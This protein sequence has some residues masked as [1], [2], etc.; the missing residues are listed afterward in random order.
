LR[1]GGGVMASGT[2]IA[3]GCS[4]FCV[5]FITSC[6]LLGSS[7]DTLEP[8]DMGIV[9]D[10]NVQHLEE[11]QLYFGGRYLVG[12]GRKFI[13]FPK[14]Y[15]TIR[16]GL[17]S[18]DPPSDNIVCRSHDGLSIDVEM[19]FQFMFNQDAGDLWRLYMALGTTVNGVFGLIAQEVVQNVFSDYYTLDFFQQRVAMETAIFDELKL[20]LSTFFVTVTSVELMRVDIEDTSPDLVSAV[21]TTQVAIQ[22]VFQA[23]AEQAVAQVNADA[24]VGVATEVAQVQLLNANATA[25]SYLAAVQASADALLYRIDKQATALLTLRDQLGLNTSMEV[26]GYQWLIAMQEN[27]VP[28]L[29]VG[30]QYPT[31]LQSVFNR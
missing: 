18:F 9:L 19:S 23:I 22:D 14:T 13:A 31:V 20:A 30:L 27:T 11:N 5:V 6:A 12:L 8:N 10:S 15:Q 17:S 28:D 29:V 1:C 3:L 7:F 16:F 2:Q 26:L 24:S 25:I 21:E 4:L